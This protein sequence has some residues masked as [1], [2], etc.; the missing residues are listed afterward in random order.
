MKVLKSV[1]LFFFSLLFFSCS[2]YFDFLDSINP[3]VE[4]LAFEQ[5]NYSLKENGVAACYIVSSP[6]DVLSRFEAQYSIRNENVAVII[7]ECSNYCIIRAENPGCTVLEA[8]IS[9]KK[10]EAI[11]TVE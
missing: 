3:A 2:S 6:Q 8:S 4:S 1:F 5:G 7:K 10:C 9:G 11:I